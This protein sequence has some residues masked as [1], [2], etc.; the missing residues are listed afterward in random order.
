MSECGK[1]VELMIS[2]TVADTSGR[3]LSGQTI[4]AFLASIGHTNLL[5]VGLN[6]SFGQRSKD[7]KPYLEELSAEFFVNILVC[8]CLS[9]CRFAQSVWRVRRNSRN[10]GAPDQRYLM[11]K[12]R[13]SLA[14][15]VEQRLIILLPIS[16]FY[17]I[18]RW[19][20]R[21]L[22]ILHPITKNSEKSTDAEDILWQE[23]KYGDFIWAVFILQRKIEQNFTWGRMLEIQMMRK[24][25]RWMYSSPFSPSSTYRHSFLLREES[26]AKFRSEVL[27]RQHWRTM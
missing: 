3:T 23:T 7:L 17:L 9:Q 19:K 25:I 16:R 6:C 22:E 2:A 18:E 5:S 12:T 13:T 21:Q 4:R 15:A 11:K 8:K 14:D 26:E 1:R 20:L 10:N 27:I 24:Q